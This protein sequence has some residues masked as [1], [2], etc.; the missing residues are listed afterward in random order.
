VDANEKKVLEEISA[1]LAQMLQGKKPEYLF[2]YEN[3]SEPLSKLVKYVNEI[4]HSFFEIWDFIQPLCKG[5]LSIEPPGTGNILASP[6]KELHSQLR[7]LVW[8]VQQIAKGD[9]KQR[10]FFMGEFSDAFNSMVEALEEK[11]RLI[12]EYIA[13]LEN[14]AKKLKESESRY[15]LA[16]RNSPGGIYIFDPITMK[17]LESNE[18]FNRMMGYCKEDIP[19]LTVYD[20]YIDKSAAQEDIN[21]ILRKSL[22]NIS[23]RKYRIKNGGYIDVD[24]SSCWSSSGQSNVVIVSVRDVTERN[25]AQEIAAKYKVLFENARDIILFVTPDGG[26][27]EANKAAENAYGYTRDELLSLD[28][29]KLHSENDRKIIEKYI[30]EADIAGVTFETVHIRKDGTSFPVEIS[31]QGIVIGNQKIIAKVIRDISERKR[32]ED[33]L[34][35]FTSHDFLTRIP[36]RRVLEEAYTRTFV[37][38]GRTD[39]AGALLLIDVDNFKFVNDTFGHAVGDMILVDLVSVLKEK[40][41]ENMCKEALLA[42]LGSDEFAVLLNNVTKQEAEIIAEKLRAAVEQAKFSPENLKFENRKFSLSYTVSIG[43]TPIQGGPLEFKEVVT[44][45]DYALYQSKEHG[46][47]RVYCISNEEEINNE[48]N[49]TNNLMLLIS[50]AIEEGRFVLFFQPV[51]DVLSGEITHHEALMRLI[52][53]NGEAVYPGNVIPIAERFGLMP[54][55]DRQIVKLSFDALEEYPQLKL[56][57]NLSGASIGDEELLVL[58]ENN[59]KNRGIEPSRIGFEITETMA[60][61]NLTRANQWIRRLRE[62]G[63]RFALDDFGMGFSFSYLQY[64]SVDYVKIDGSYVRDLDR[65]YKNRALVQAMNMVASSCGKKVIAEFVENSKVLNILK[66]DNINYAQG[67]FL[68]QPK[69]VPQFGY[70]PV[71]HQNCIK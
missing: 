27:I 58:I 49:D 5:M 7:N 38:A 8:Q 69:P 16:V 28:I 22:H 42:R 50:K 40:L 46:K 13:H 36:N 2:E 23:N 65:N 25:R 14:E 63:C 45:A 29:Y 61:K 4:I 66:E 64:L 33:N 41:E 39:A 12:K 43:L 17:I 32:M 48:I 54:K 19:N 11:D 18:Q 35:Y 53:E 10:V 70:I 20:F 67:Y 21:N 57:V 56:F 51:V 55:I 37:Q 30:Q 60:V 62:K 26:V 1:A 47:N 15:A 31:S 44:R 71:S 3:C 52:A 68:G 6:F 34:H 9:Y 24:I 59:I